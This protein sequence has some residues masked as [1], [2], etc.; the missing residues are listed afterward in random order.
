MICRTYNNKIIKIYNYSR[1]QAVF[2]M[3]S[4]KSIHYKIKQLY[5][6]AQKKYSKAL[7]N[8]D[9]KEL[10]NYEKLTK[11]IL[12]LSNG[13]TKLRTLKKN[14]NNQSSENLINWKNI[15]KICLHQS[16]LSIDSLFAIDH[17]FKIR[18]NF[19]K[20]IIRQG[21]D[22]LI[23]EFK[24]Y[25]LG[26]E[27][28]NLK[29]HLF[30][31]WNM[32]LIRYGKIRFLEEIQIRELAEKLM[33]PFDVHAMD[34]SDPEI[35]KNTNFCD[36]VLVKIYKKYPEIIENII[37]RGMCCIHNKNTLYTKV[38]EKNYKKLFYAVVKK[39]PTL[40]FI[41]LFASYTNNYNYHLKCP[42]PRA[43]NN[44]LETQFYYLEIKDLEVV[45]RNDRKQVAIK[46]SDSDSD[47][48]FDGGPE[49]DT[50][51]D[52]MEAMQSSYD[53]E[54]ENMWKNQDWVIYILYAQGSKEIQKKL[55]IM[56]PLNRLIKKLKKNRLTQ[57]YYSEKANKNQLLPK[58]IMNNIVK[59]IGSINIF[60]ASQ[61]KQT[62]NQNTDYVEPVDKY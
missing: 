17:N 27:I 1:Y 47:S 44:P 6:S 40:V 5:D 62:K 51:I 43:I 60:I 59:Y 26:E 20:I 16:E 12:K 15:N 38:I 10:K 32:M 36:L 54:I 46:K 19:I 21:N 14:I 57:Q 42:C 28:V 29:D 7:E 48:D 11:Y 50:H 45:N 58:V 49:M 53:E 23:R 22:N 31:I 24:S 37:K 13:K 33:K 41:M 34:Y 52:R 3:K 35:F 39:N 55:E 9:K 25:I 56:Y 61:P 4:I 30:I 18:N 8:N 2:P